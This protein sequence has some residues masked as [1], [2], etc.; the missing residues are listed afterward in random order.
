MRDMALAEIANF[1]ADMGGTN[2]LDP[3]EQAQN[4]SIAACE[5]STVSKAR[6]FILTD[7]QVSNSKQVIRKAATQNDQCRVFT[8]GLGDG[9]D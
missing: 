2:I 1:Q 5:G 3:L 9:C 8:F 4:M 7:G 6:I